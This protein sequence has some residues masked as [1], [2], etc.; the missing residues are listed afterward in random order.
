[1]E[2]LRVFADELNDALN[3]IPHN[4]ADTFKNNAISWL[5]WAVGVAA[6]VVIIVSAIKM[7]TSAGDPG[8]VQKAKQ[9]LIYAIV[10]L[11]VAVLAYVIVEFVL[12]SLG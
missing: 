2:K 1:M 12:D 4:S 3:K 10:G 8:A 9:T 7:T 5:F 6:V 11:V